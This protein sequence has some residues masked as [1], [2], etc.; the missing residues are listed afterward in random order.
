MTGRKFEGKVA[1]ITGSSNGI[2]RGIASHFAGLRAKITITGRSEADL[3]ETKKQCLEAGAKAED[4]HDLAGDLGCEEFMDKLVSSTVEKFGRLDYLINNAGVGDQDN[5]G[6]KPGFFSQDMTSFDYIFKINLRCPVYLIRKSA[7]HLESAKGAIVNIS[8]ICSSEGQACAFSFY[9]MSK[10]AMD[11]MTRNL[12]LEMIAKGVRV[13]A[14]RPGAVVSAM[15]QKQGVSDAVAEAAREQYAK[16]FSLIPV[17]RMGVP[18]D[19]AKLTAYL[20]DGNESS[21]LIAQEPYP[22]RD[23]A[24]KIRLP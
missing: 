7:P 10:A 6:K 21:Y 24:E 3:A 14:I 23:T 4:I 11:Q 9:A 17:Q 1:L 22:Q 18:E 16:D 5:S 13:N 20:C 12:A 8:S 2:G 15:H 19:V